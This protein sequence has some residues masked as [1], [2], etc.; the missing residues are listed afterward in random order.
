MK[1][2]YIHK[3]IYDEKGTIVKVVTQ[4]YDDNEMNETFDVNERLVLAYGDILKRQGI[5]KRVEYVDLVASYE[6]KI[7]S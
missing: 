7:C 5:N 4:V 3:I 1:Q 2:F 6:F